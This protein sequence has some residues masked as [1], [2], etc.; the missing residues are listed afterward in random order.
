MARK[1]YITG[2]MSFDEQ[3]A[4]IADL[5]PV[6]ALIWPWLLTTFDDWGRA[7]ASPRRLKSQVFPANSLIT[8]EKIEESLQL[9]NQAGLLSLY[10]VDG[11]IYMAIE[12][13]KWWSWQTHVKKEK[14]E[15]DGSHIPAPPEDC[16]RLQSDARNRKQAQSDATDCKQNLASPLLSSP[17]PSPRIS[18]PPSPTPSRAKTAR[19]CLS[20]SQEFEEF[21]NSY[22]RKLEK[23]K[24]WKCWLT[25][26]KEGFKTSAMISAAK[27]YG[28]VCQSRGCPE[29]KIKHP[30]TF[31]NSETPFEDYCDGTPEE[32]EQK[33]R[34][35]G[36]HKTQ[37][38]YNPAGADWEHEPATLL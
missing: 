22:P 31:L 27:N 18:P 3:I 15:C 25:R 21:W 38:H 11:K 24:A 20:Y 29:D 37:Q 9:Y 30:A 4:E 6:A 23:K 12:P 26:L 33:G 10:E 1:I 5:D 14:K 19:G 32:W 13:E 35:N 7:N 16:K 8:I 2:D 36:T 28:A 34:D 17:P